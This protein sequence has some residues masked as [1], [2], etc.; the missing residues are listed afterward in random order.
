MMT[1]NSNSLAI[2]SWLSAALLTILAATL[3]LSPRLLVFLSGTAISLTSLEA[4]LTLHFGIFLAALALT[5]V[6]NV[7]SPK[8]PVPSDEVS[9]H[10][11]LTPLTV[12]TNISAFLA[13]NTKDVGALSSIVFLISMTIG[14]WGLWTIVF[15]NSS[16]IS[17]TTGADKH[18]SAFIFGNEAAASS[19]KKKFKKGERL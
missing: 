12:A 4:F 5:L 16:S 17:K 11:L 19:Q 18:T 14:L 10:P 2:W 13:W 3:T 1:D 7:P 6:L 9:S 15:A 8:P